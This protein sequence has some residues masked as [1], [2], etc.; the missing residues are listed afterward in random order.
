ME[1][2]TLGDEFTNSTAAEN[3]GNQT[4]LFDL[5][6]II[7]QFPG[8]TTSQTITFDSSEIADNRYLSY[9]SM[10]FPSNDAF[11]ANDDPTEVPI[12]D[13]KG[14][15]IGAEFIIAGNEVWDAGTEVN[16]ESPL[17]VPLNGSTLI[18][19]ADT[20]ELLAFVVAP[21]EAVSNTKFVNAE[22]IFLTGNS[23]TTGGEV[24]EP[25]QRELPP[26]Q[27]GKIVGTSN[28][29][30]LVGNN[31]ANLI[32]AGGSDDFVNAGGGSDR[33]FG[34]D[35]NDL[36]NGGAGA[37]VLNGG[38]GKD[39]LLGETGNDILNGDRGK[40]ILRGGSGGNVISGG[41]GN[42]LLNGGASNDALFGDRGR[43]IFVFA[44][45]GD[46]DIIFDNT[47][48]LLRRVLLRLLKLTQLKV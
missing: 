42:D 19:D 23:P 46:A 7:G 22:K 10:F 39:T 28:P 36:L 11:I 30:I 26:A 21:A 37:D 45:D 38:N 17:N 16:D 20:G 34:E 9:A 33:I 18:S 15:F 32:L 12:F 40:D 2:K 1:G 13:E 35:G 25:I 31:R 24:N 4:L 41:R 14:N 27:S 47:E 5:E 3:G 8:V 43:D 29:D 6:T 44:P 48:L